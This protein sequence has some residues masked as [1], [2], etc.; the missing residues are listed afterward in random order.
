MKMLK[1]LAAAALTITVTLA[2]A[3][4]AAAQVKFKN[5]Y[6]FK[7]GLMEANPMPV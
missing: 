2:L 3:P 5:I 7:G 1:V 4:G 6:K